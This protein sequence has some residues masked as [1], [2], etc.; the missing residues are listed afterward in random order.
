MLT[1]WCFPSLSLFPFRTFSLPPF[2]SSLLLQIPAL[3]VRHESLFFGLC[4]HSLATTNNILISFASGARCSCLRANPIASSTTT[5]SL[6]CSG[7]DR[8]RRPRQRCVAF[9][10]RALALTEQRNSIFILILI[11][12]NGRCYLW[13][14]ALPP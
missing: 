4:S 2:S 11:S 10:L 13:M 12:I 1:R 6:P 7:A 9:R 5:R 3:A 14:D 8:G